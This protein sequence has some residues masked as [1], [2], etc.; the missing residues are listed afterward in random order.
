M[1]LKETSFSDVE[2]NNGCGNTYM[3]ICTQFVY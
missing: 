3:V 1:Q 2:Q